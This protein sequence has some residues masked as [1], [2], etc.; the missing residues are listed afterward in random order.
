MATTV[1]FIRHA[2]SDFNIKD[3]HTRPLTAEGQQAA[4]DLL[5]VFSNTEFSTIYSSPYQRT[6][7]TV[8]PLAISK[9]ISI[10]ERADFRERCIG[11]WVED[12][13]SYARSQ[14]SDFDFKIEG[15]E[16]LRAVQERNIDLL[17]EILENH[18]NETIAIGTHG[19]ALGAIINHYDKSFDFDRFLSIVDK[20]PIIVEFKFNGTAFES[21]KICNDLLG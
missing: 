11:Q 13:E 3:D 21:Y 10:Q 15:G 6:I 20:M 7:D 1:Y 14:W 16:S 12:F 5:S 9:G 19:T 18:S 2:E 8:K 4:Q 17:A